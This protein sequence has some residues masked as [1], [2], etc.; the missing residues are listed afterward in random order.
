MDFENNV[1]NDSKAEYYDI[2]ENSS[3]LSVKIP[4]DTFTK[5]IEGKVRELSLF[6]CLDISGS[7]SGSAIIQAKE[8]ILQLMGEL[9]NRKIL[10]EKDVTCFF[11][12]HACEVK[13][14]SEDPNMLWENGKIR[15]FFDTVKSG[16]GTDFG[17]VFSSIIENLEKVMSENLAIIFFTDGQNGGPDLEGNKRNLASALMN[18]PLNTEVHSIGFTSGHDAALLLWLVKCAKKEG[19]FQYV[20]SSGDIPETMKITFE[21]LETGDRTFYL[22]IGDR[23]P[24]PVNFDGNGFGKVALAGD[25]SK[26][27]GQSIIVKKSIEAEVN[28]SEIEQCELPVPRRILEDDPGS[29]LMVI[30]FIEIEVTRLS[31]EVINDNSEQ[32]TKRQR[33]NEILE[34]ANKYDDKVNVI[35]QNAFRTRSVKRRDIIQQCMTVKSTINSF[36]TILSE[37][38][39]GTLTNEKIANFNNIAY[40]NITKQRLKGRLNDRA[41]KNIDKMEDVEKKIEKIVNSLDFDKLESEETEENL[42]T[43]SCMISTDNYIEAMKEGECICLTLDVSR[44]QAAIADPSQVNVKKINQTFLSSGAFLDSVKFALE[45][46]A[47]ENVHGGFQFSLFGQS[48]IQ[49]MARENITGILPLYINEKHWSIAREKMKPIMG[50]VTTLDMFGYAYSQVTTV[51]FLVLAKALSDTSSEFRRRQFKLILD[52][53][54]AIYKESKNLREENKQLF[55]KYMESPLNRTIDVVPNNLVYLGHLLC[56]LRCGDVT[57]QDLE[58]WLK[59]RLIEYLMEETIRRKLNKFTLIEEE[60]KDVSKVLGIDKREY[61]E[62]P[63]NQ[64][65]NDYAEYIKATM[66]A[67]KSVNVRY[68]IAIQKALAD[69]GVNYEVDIESQQDVESKTKEFHAPTIK[70]Q[71]YN[72][73]TFQV[74]ETS[75]IK[76]IKD[77]FAGTAETIL[78]FNKIFESFITTNSSL[79]SCLESPEFHFAEDKTTLA[80]SFFDKYP[81]KVQVATLLQSYMHRQ[82]SERRDAVVSEPVR[83]HEPFSEKTADTIIET[84]FNEYVVTNLNNGS[85]E[86]V[87]TFTAERDDALGIIFWRLESEEQAAGFLLEEVKF[88]GRKF[89]AQML[90]ALQRGGLCLPKEKISMV[91]RG[92]WKGIVLFSDKPK[93]PEDPERMARFISNAKWRPS[94]RTIYRTIKAQRSQI[95]DVKWWIDLVPMHKDYLE[96]QFDNE[97]MKKLA[98]QRYEAANGVVNN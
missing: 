98:R 76:K 85:S 44:S 36:K 4:Q 17:C 89:F 58:S 55:E 75:I 88:R 77:I 16:G 21:L 74:P 43:F 79:E 12:N 50:Y 37:A 61:I 48:A 90:K 81:L 96:L 25:S 65:R 47:P 41:I 35:V 86:I 91:I 42:L 27:E 67:D 60:M 10:S 92:E 19:N 80:S 94:R 5:W 51:P 18:S 70:T 23:N 69:I 95:P 28:T 78:R 93:H 83:Y 26:V 66:D 82:N 97:L 62:D 57:P 31:N 52:T 3:I 9:F 13:R 72:S 8:A 84:Y 39:K 6:V 68:S 34:L 11:F 14:F 7:M 40:K 29:A 38:L 59:N 22:Q 30:P 56:A 87:K 71:L 63:I 53:C 20:K 33:F 2:D 54:N 32:E 15:S 73:T 45:E 1:N 46:N 64:F 24:L 49:G